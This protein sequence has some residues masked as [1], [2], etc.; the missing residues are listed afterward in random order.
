MSLVLGLELVPVFQL[1][2]ERGN[3]VMETSKCSDFMES[4]VLG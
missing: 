1:M 2:L 3:M 4:E